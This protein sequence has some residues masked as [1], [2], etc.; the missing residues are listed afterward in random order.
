MWAFFGTITL[1]GTAIPSALRWP[2]PAFL[3]PGR[4]PLANCPGFPAVSLCSA[5]EKVL[6]PACPNALGAARVDLS[7]GVT[8]DPGAGQISVRPTH[9]GV[10]GVR[11]GERTLIGFLH[12]KMGPHGSSMV[13]PVVL[14]PGLWVREKEVTTMSLDKL[15]G[16]EMSPHLWVA[17]SARRGPI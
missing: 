4:R 10:W 7:P 17:L 1:L 12:G 15:L 5:L 3:W 14:G 11:A 6:W 2:L 9:L 13:P 16:V 8:P